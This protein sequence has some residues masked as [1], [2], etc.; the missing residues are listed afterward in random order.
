MQLPRILPAVAVV[1]TTLA[2][3]WSPASAGDPGSAGLLSMRLAVGARNGA[4]G[5]TGVASAFDGS[6]VFW[7]PANM[8]YTA[9]T[10]MT[11]QHMEYLGLFRKES[12]AVTHQTDYGSLGL[13][14][15][16]FYSE[17][18]DRTDDEPAG[19]RLG[20]FQPYDLV[21]GLGYAYRFSQVAIGITGKIIYERIDTY[22][23]RYG[24]E[25]YFV[26]RHGRVV[27]EAGNNNDT[28]ANIKQMG[29][30][31][32]IAPQVLGAERGDWTYERG[33]EPYML[34]S[35][36]IE[37]LGWLLLVEQPE[38]TAT[39]GVRRAFLLN[40]GIGLVIAILVVALTHVT[41]RHYQRQLEHIA[42]TDNLTGVANRRSF[43]MLAGAAARHRCDDAPPDSVIL[44]DLDH[45][46]RINDHYGHVTGDQVIRQAAGV[47]RDA[48]RATDVLCRWG[49]EEFAV[50]LRGCSLADARQLAE[51][52][53]RAISGTKFSDHEL[54]VTASF[55][56][57]AH[58][59]G[60]SLAQT[61]TRADQAMYTAKNRGRDRV[62]SA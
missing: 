53:R 21:I 60:E 10:Q 31:G 41:I 17:E 22:E 46:K 23:Q 49:G 43:E 8:A 44:F 9:G 48:L 24:R 28:P 50:W 45:L 35:R 40:L 20:T 52:M 25:I 2:V 19:V 59:P 61:L 16:G 37:E 13:L 51:T 12:L 47:A 34:N 39:A 14:F 15:S 57:V 55:G 27:L 18:L 5:D 6:A 26:D 3:L 33:G 42:M 1:A 11:L 32:A 29:G 54:T 7:N 58:Q 30:L 38:S 56:V 4:M 62:Q 36:Y